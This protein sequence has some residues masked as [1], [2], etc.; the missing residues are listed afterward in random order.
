MAMPRTV[1][2]RATRLHWPFSFPMVLSRQQDSVWQMRVAC[3]KVTGIGRGTSLRGRRA[4]DWF[5]E[6]MMAF[7]DL[8]K[9]AA[10]G[11]DLAK[12]GEPAER[13]SQVP[14]CGD[15]RNRESGS[16]PVQKAVV[17]GHH[18]AQTG[19]SCAAFY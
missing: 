11:A 5:Q 4:R 10:N 6:D 12:R 8:H 1:R 15:V 16:R 2:K 13:V 9:R 18:P 19:V 3:P 17:C 14:V 7:G